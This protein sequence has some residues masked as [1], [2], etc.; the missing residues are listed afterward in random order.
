MALVTLALPVE[1]EAP[2]RL[3]VGPGPYN[4]HDLLW[5]RPPIDSVRRRRLGGRERQ[6]VRSEATSSLAPPAPRLRKSG[7]DQDQ[8]WRW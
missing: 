1:D 5:P 2:S 6:S 3:D 4:V 7:N 8:R